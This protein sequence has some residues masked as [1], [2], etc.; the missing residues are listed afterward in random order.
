MYFV[1]AV[2]LAIVAAEPIEALYATSTACPPCARI[3]PILFALA[4]EGWQIAKFDTGAQPDIAAGWH[5]TSTPTIVFHQGNREL[6]RLT[7]DHDRASLLA[8]FQSAGVAFSPAA[9]PQQAKATAP[10]CPGGVCVV[11]PKPAAKLPA[12]PKLS[13]PPVLE[14]HEKYSDRT[15]GAVYERVTLG[16][17][18]PITVLDPASYGCLADPDVGYPDLAAAVKEVYRLAQKHREGA[19][20]APKA[21]PQ[22]DPPDVQ[23]TL[24]DIPPE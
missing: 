20:D 16:C 10:C 22:P 13:D 15:S 5:V 12:A 19:D 14:T 4:S 11:P 23:V 1:A 3:E 8:A 24:V 21:V 6:S 18:C 7:G 9:K 17:G 2:L